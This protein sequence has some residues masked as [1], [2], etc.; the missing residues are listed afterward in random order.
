MVS[1]QGLGLVCGVRPN[2]ANKIFWNFVGDE[3]FDLKEVGTDLGIK[4]LVFAE[5]FND[6]YLLGIAGIF[7]GVTVWGVLGMV[8][9]ELQVGFGEL[10]RRLILN[11]LSTFCML[12]VSF[13]EGL[14]DALLDSFCWTCGALADGGSFV[15]D[16][17]GVELMNN[18]DEICTG[19]T[20]VL[21]LGEMGVKK[22]YVPDQ[23][24]DTGDTDF[25]NVTN[26]A[27][28][29]EI[30]EAVCTN[31]GADLK[32]TTPGDSQIEVSLLEFAQKFDITQKK[33]RIGGDSLK[34]WEYSEHT[35][36]SQVLYK[37]GNGERPCLYATGAPGRILWECTHYKDPLS[38]EVRFIEEEFREMLQKTVVG[39]F[40]SQMLKA[41]AVSVK[42]VDMTEVDQREVDAWVE[43]ESCDRD[44]L[45]GSTFL[46]IFGVSDEVRPDVPRAVNILQNA[47]I[48]VRIFTGESQEY[49]IELA[50]RLGLLQTNFIPTSETT[51]V[52][53]ADQLRS[54][55]KPELLHKL[56]P[57]R[58]LSTTKT[59]HSES[60]P[61]EVARPPQ[62]HN[63]TGFLSLC[64]NLSII[65]KA[66]SD[67][68]L[69][70]I[71]GLSQG[72][73]TVALISAKNSDNCALDRAHI[74]I[75]LS[76]NSTD[77]TKDISNMILTDPSL[78]GLLNSVLF[79]RNMFDNLQKLIAF[80]LT[81]NFSLLATNLLAI[82][83][84]GESPVPN[85]GLI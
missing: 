12:L 73:R 41:V 23:M 25:C 2:S 29:R 54:H 8:F 79:G 19:V 37:R 58:A 62:I 43:K 76:H 44:L 68:K 35:G 84:Y 56:S 38:K 40:G 26:T 81:T 22:V 1:G 71:N 57:D 59:A 55:T 9:G 60:Q 52:L 70:F 49:G 63:L 78:S 83:F 7:V 51:C 14:P 21:T 28:L 11:I 10:V 72:S 82:V 16:G 61:Q 34:I 32:D 69:Q 66:T 74:G 47:G 3:K 31:S 36:V 17:T 64:K 15:K 80:S 33:V 48:R 65:S 4:I 77:L 24:L 30:L 18:C 27:M 39:Q 13:S 5:G 50:K 20:G 67:D 75:S 85:C 46:G 53:R 45:F 42:Y 6:R